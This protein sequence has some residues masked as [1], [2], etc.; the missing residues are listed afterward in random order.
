MPDFLTYLSQRLLG[1]DSPVEPKSISRGRLQRTEIPAP[2]LSAYRTDTAEPPL[3]P[4]ASP[5]YTSLQSPTSTPPVTE[6]GSIRLPSE[7]LPD[8]RGKDLAEAMERGYGERPEKPHAVPSL[9]GIGSRTA[10]PSVVRHVPPLAPVSPERQVPTRQ[11]GKEVKTFTAESK[12]KTTSGTSPLPL[13]QPAPLPDRPPPLSSAETGPDNRIDI[14]EGGRKRMA[15]RT[16]E[17]MAIKGEKDISLIISNESE[18]KAG[19]HTDRTETISPHHS[20][21]VPEHHALQQRTEPLTFSPSE[22]WG[23]RR[24]DVDLVSSRTINV[25]IGRIE[26]RGI[27]EQKREQPASPGTRN[28]P[29]PPFAG[30]SLGEFLKE[31]GRRDR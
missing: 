15:E 12:R 23:S 7:P 8:G 24:K 18:T 30:I 25:T 14:A 20:L 6:P 3:A 4:L 13:L 11:Q 22:R 28:R 29:Q 9:N 1:S 26:V 2:A 27:A 5:H 31:Y 17:T 19:E 10:E 16:G 21:L